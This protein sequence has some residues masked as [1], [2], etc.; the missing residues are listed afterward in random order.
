[1]RKIKN[2]QTWEMK[3]I[4]ND[5]KLLIPIILIARK[6]LIISNTRK[7]FL[8]LKILIV[9]FIFYQTFNV[10]LF[11]VKVYSIHIEKHISF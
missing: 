2:V 8:P 5:Q 4:M 1:M 7:D 3:T 10:F 11:T 6:S 9:W